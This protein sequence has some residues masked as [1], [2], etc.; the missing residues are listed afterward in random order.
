MCAQQ[1]WNA[2]QSSHQ[3]FIEGYPRQATLL[4]ER[5]AQRMVVRNQILIDAPA[6]MPAFL[7]WFDRRFLLR[8][9]PLEQ[10]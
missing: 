7:D 2:I 10:L 5:L 4:C 8:A 9:E 6:E 1:L 3:D